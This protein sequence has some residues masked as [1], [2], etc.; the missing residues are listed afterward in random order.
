MLPKPKL[1]LSGIEKRVEQHASQEDQKATVG[2]V[3]GAWAENP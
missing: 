2:E 3:P 1:R